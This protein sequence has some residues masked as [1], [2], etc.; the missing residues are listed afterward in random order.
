M[1]SQGKESSQH[2]RPAPDRAVLSFDL[3]QNIGSAR[4]FREL[5]LLVLGL[6]AVAGLAF[7]RPE[8]SDLENAGMAE[9]IPSENKM[10]AGPRS[11][12]GPDAPSALPFV[13]T[14]PPVQ[15]DSF[16]PPLE[17]RAPAG[18]RP[19]AENEKNL[20]LKRGDTLMAAM[21]RAGA[22][23]KDAYHAIEALSDHVNLRKI[24]VGQP[25]KL[26]FNASEAGGN[27]PALSSLILQTAF[28][29]KV[30]SARAENG[31]F[32]AH[33]EDIA[34]LPLLMYGQGEITD[35][36]FLS[37]RRAGLPPQAIIELIRIFSFDVDFQR[38]IRR[39]DSFEILFERRISSE[40]GAVENG[41]VLYASLTLRGRRLQLYRHMP[42]DDNRAD[43]FDPE[44]QSARKA[45]MK[46]PIDGARLTSSYG[47]R[48]HPV[49]GYNRMHRGSDFRAPTGT[50]IMAAG[51]G[52][53]ERAS[54]YGAYGNYVSIR[55]N[56]TYKT[57]YAHLSRYAKGVKKGARV[58]QGQIIGYS[59]ATGRVTAAH[60][61]YEV[62]VDGAQVNPMTLNLPTG[63]KLDDQA[64]AAFDRT[65]ESI[66][67]DLAL[68]RQSNG[69]IATIAAP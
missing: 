2:H 40:T 32:S 41:N 30:I 47:M 26:T 56:G 8:L 21:V 38:E 52:V 39:G 34:I 61:H 9:E 16:G 43:Y 67:A 49:L 33:G 66:A 48:K 23:R 53:V 50:P 27:G 45:L 54:R 13:V 3:G 17:K 58:K 4:W 36:L 57:A 5:T 19:A 55:H 63:R 37:A 42:D 11:P 35:S 20:T 64:L 68:L 28:D 25:I 31:G 6:A 44:G 51:D 14:S 62:L 24:Q 15:A 29:Q 22:D 65:R 7:F 10:P 46:T 18:I 59:G 60:L 12:Q 1:S 69:T